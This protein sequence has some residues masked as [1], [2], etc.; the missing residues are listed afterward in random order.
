MLFYLTCSVGV[1]SHRRVWLYFF[2]VWGYMSPLGGWSWYYA[3]DQSFLGQL[4][5]QPRGR[6][7]KPCKA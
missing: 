7:L 6:D 3:Q 1:A 2:G 5:G 4:G